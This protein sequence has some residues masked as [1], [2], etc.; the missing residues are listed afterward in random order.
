[1]PKT[2]NFRSLLLTSVV[3]LF[4]QLAVAQAEQAI[5]RGY[6]RPPKP[7]PEILDARPTPLILPSPKSDYLLVVDRLG[8]PPIYDLS[9]P[10][11]RLARFRI[12][13]ITNGRHIQ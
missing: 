5:V 1:M 8:N 10:M 12:N 7:I 3:V 6:Q 2:Q 4:A 9:Q 13:P 11:L